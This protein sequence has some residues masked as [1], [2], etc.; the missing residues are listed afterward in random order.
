MRDAMR[1][2][3]AVNALLDVAAMVLSIWCWHQGW[4][5][6]MV[7]CWLLG[8][9]F[10]H[11]M[12]LAFHEAA[13][14]N[15]CRRRWDNELRGRVMGFISL[16]PLSAYRYVHKF[17][18]SDLCSSKDAEFWPYNQTHI[19]RWIRILSAV[20][21]LTLGYLV[22]SLQFLRG[23]LVTPPEDPRVRRQILR[24]YLVIVGLWGMVLATVHGTGVWTEFLVGY[25]IPAL[26]ASNLQSW[27]KFIEHMGLLGDS[28][29]ALT[30]TVVHRSSPGMLIERMM[31]NESHHGTHHCFAGV[32][33]PDL[34]SKTRTGLPASPGAT[35]IFTSYGTALFAML[36]SL[37]DP[38]VGRQ[39]RVHPK[40]PG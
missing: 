19:P 11:T 35:S 10:G 18:H 5:V 3:S 39:W 23:V 22:T 38:R 20:A 40:E 15:L 2:P 9:H 27:R 36:P 37:A 34:P 7:G 12:L 1:Y 13:H 14:F 25:L 16:V 8:A 6:A 4:Y 26:L 32:P 28:P 33:H 17:H 30:R 21:E 31:L 29:E 24:G